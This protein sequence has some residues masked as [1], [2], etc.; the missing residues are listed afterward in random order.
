MPFFKGQ[1][2]T[3]KRVFLKIIR[4][5]LMKL[6]KK[7]KYSGTASGFTL[8]ELLVVIAIIG[9]LASIIFIGL[10]NTRKVARDV[11]RIADMKQIVTALDLFYD[12]N[13]YY[14]NS[15]DP[16]CGGWDTPGDG[17][18]LEILHEHNIIA[19]NPHD[20]LGDSPCGN[21]AYYRYAAGSFYCDIS[22]GDFYVLGIPNLES[23]NGERW[24]ATPGWKCADSPNDHWEEFD[25]VVG[26]YEK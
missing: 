11:K 13:G 4:T 10:N 12:T 6:F 16:Q 1:Y 15:T 14:P 21:Y 25:W 8:I 5:I 18:F 22:R 17:D 3:T 9:L 2:F 20:P 26:A 23:T 24:P 7:A 19:S